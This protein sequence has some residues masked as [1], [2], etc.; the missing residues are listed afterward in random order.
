[1]LLSCRRI[2]LTLL[3]DGQMMPDGA[4]DGGTRHSVVSSEVSADTA[5]CGT[6]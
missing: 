2:S 4:A 6:A 1:M 5:H 3:F